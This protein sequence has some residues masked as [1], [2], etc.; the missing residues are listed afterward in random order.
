[1][2]PINSAHI[3]FAGWLKGIHP[4]FHNRDNLVEWMNSQDTTKSLKNAFH[5]APQRIVL[6]NK[7]NTKTITQGIRIEVAFE[8]KMEVLALL[9]TIPWNEGPYKHVQFIPFKTNIH[10][11]IE[12][13]R[14]AIRQHN[15]YMSQ[16]KQKVTKISGAAHEISYLTE[17]S[18]KTTLQKWLQNTTVD[19]SAKVFEQVELGEQDFVRFIYR[20]K[21]ELIV[22]QVLTNLYSEMTQVFGEETTNN[23]IKNGNGLRIDKNLADME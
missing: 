12:N 13:Q 20:S 15:I 1:M 6:T 11:T 19:G 14:E 16:I 22:E 17:P 3:F 18:S 8:K 4:K 21:N 5:V 9:Y 2:T 7:D 10:F 23:M